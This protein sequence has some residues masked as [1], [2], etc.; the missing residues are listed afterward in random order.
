MKSISLKTKIVTG[1][2]IGGMIL[3]SAITTFAATPNP[4]ITDVKTPLRNEC[5]K[6][7]CRGEQRLDTNLKK[8]VTDKTL[9]QD[10]SN[11]IKAAITKA[12]TAKKASF[13]E[14]KTMTEAQRK[15]YINIY[16]K[17]HIS[18]LKSLVEN[19]TITQVQADKVGLGGHHGSGA[20][21]H[22]IPN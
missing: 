3:S 8:L 22:K 9:T 17:N 4:L 21:N 12:K 10:Q 20:H 19:G 16:K 14:T 7:D 18:P 11:K 1:S 5:R 2:L 6:M 13:E 15:T